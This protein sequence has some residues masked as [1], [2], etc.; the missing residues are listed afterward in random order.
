MT[1]EGREERR[2]REKYR[3]W[4]GVILKV[5]LVLELNHAKEGDRVV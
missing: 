1:K 2:E 4:L 3:G 5:R